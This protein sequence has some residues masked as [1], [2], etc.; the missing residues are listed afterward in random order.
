[1][2]ASGEVSKT[3]ITT[4]GPDEIVGATLAASGVDAPQVRPA[5]PK[6]SVSADWFIRGYE[7]ERIHLPAVA[8]AAPDV[9]YLREHRRLTGFD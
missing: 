6:R 1:M 9:M 3:R 5:G 4:G 7:G 8:E 2:E